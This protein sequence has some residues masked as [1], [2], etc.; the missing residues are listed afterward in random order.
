MKWSLSIVMG[1]Y[2]IFC[3]HYIH[4]K[5]GNDENGSENV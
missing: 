4:F 5:L 3:F 2:I 1:K